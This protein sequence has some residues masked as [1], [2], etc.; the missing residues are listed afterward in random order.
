MK[1]FHVRDVRAFLQAS[2]GF[3]KIRA[4]KDRLPEKST[5]I[6]ASLLF[7]GCSAYDGPVL[8]LSAYTKLRVHPGPPDDPL[9]SLSLFSI[10]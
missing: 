4:D 9:L 5:P 2:F 10:Y 7:D 8:S 3:Q 1:L 6:D